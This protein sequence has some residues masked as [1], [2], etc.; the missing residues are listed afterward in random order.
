MVNM[1]SRLFNPIFKYRSILLLNRNI[2]SKV[3]KRY[4]VVNPKGQTLAVLLLGVSSVGVWNYHLI[5][6]DP[7]LND[8]PFKYV[9][10]DESVSPFP[11][12]LFTSDFTLSTNYTMLGYG[13]RSV[14]FLKFKIYALGI[15]AAD[16]DLNLISKVLDSNFLSSQFID[17]D[18]FKSHKENVKTALGDPQKSGILV[19]N[20]LDSGIRMLAKITPIRNTDLNH[21]RDG[22]IKSIL[23]HPESKCNEARISEGLDELRNAFSK[24]GSVPK[25][26]DLIIELNKDCGL[27]LYHRSRK[28]CDMIVLGHVKEPII[29]KF[30]FAQYLSGKNPLSPSTQQSVADKLSRMV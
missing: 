2:T 16:A 5:K 27:T 30:L 20:L 18:K 9:V 1:F 24:K 7:N 10:V 26:D 3:I 21:L 22:L 19:S 15:Y 6:N 17:T 29:G 11:T 23:S 8:D 28:T 14:T 12:N 25:D 4:P 13:T